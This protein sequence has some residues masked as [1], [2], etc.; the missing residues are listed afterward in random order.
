[1]RNFF[2]ENSDYFIINGFMDT[3]NSS[4]FEYFIGKTIKNGNQSYFFSNFHGFLKM[5]LPCKTRRH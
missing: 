3:K 4:L 2:A 5:L 1:M